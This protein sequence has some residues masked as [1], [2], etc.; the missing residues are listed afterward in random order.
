[1]WSGRKEVA[2][3]AM[4]ETVLEEG[5]NE[6]SPPASPTK[7]ISADYKLQVL[8]NTW[9][10]DDWHSYRDETE[11]YMRNP[12]NYND[13]NY[14]PYDDPYEEDYELEEERARYKDLT[15][16]WSQTERGSHV[17]FASTENVPLKEGRRFRLTLR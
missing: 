11:A 13:Y 9:H 6:T 17:D 12:S 3:L 8:R 15:T 16:D 4:A 1:L 2:K 14:D 5:A 10:R 7:R